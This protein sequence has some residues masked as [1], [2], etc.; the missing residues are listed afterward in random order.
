MLSLH[1]VVGCSSTHN[2]RLYKIINYILFIVF[3]WCGSIF[4]EERGKKKDSKSYLD[5]KSTLFEV[6]NNFRLYDKVYIV[7][8][9]MSLL[10]R[11]LNK[12]FGCRN[13]QICT[14]LQFCR[15]IGPSVGHSLSLLYY[16]IGLLARL[17]RL[18]FWMLRKGNWVGTQMTQTV[19]SRKPLQI[20]IF[21]RVMDSRKHMYSFLLQIG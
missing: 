21:N 9:L 5:S 12:T 16:I 7:S 18:W 1:I 8:A 17:I 13:I 2:A 11:P 6:I 14:R 19:V 4:I 10:I 20:S 15:S 3:C